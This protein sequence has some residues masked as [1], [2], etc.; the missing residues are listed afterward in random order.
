MI[1]TARSSRTRTAALLAGLALGATFGLSACGGNDAA[2]SSP[3]STPAAATAAPAGPV[4][5]AQV[6]RCLDASRSGGDARFG[7]EAEIQFSVN[8]V[9]D[10]LGVFVYP[11]AAATGGGKAQIEAEGVTDIEVVNNSVLVGGAALTDPDSQ[12]GLAKAR[13]CALSGT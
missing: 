4:P 13:S 1:T 5:A 6:E 2:P 9:G 12:A 7:A 11:D 8:K 3:A 10:N